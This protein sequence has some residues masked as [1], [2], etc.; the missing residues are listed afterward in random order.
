MTFWIL[1]IQLAA[2]FFVGLTSFGSNLFGIPLMTLVIGIKDAVIISLLATLP[3]WLLL[4]II[5]YKSMEW[6]EVLLLSLISLLTAPAGAWILAAGSPFL[7]VL[8]AGIC[9]WLILGW[10][11]L[12]RFLKREGKA[13][14][15]WLAAP[16]G[17]ISGVMIG[18]IGMG[19][20]PLM[21]YAFLR[22]W[23]KNATI[24]G[25]SLCSC[26]QMAVVAPAQWAGGLVDSG[27][28]WLSFW[29]ALAGIIGVGLSYP[30]VKKVS[31]TLFRNIMLAI[32]A[33]S[34]ATLLAK[35]FL[36]MN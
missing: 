20:P 16:V 17:L 25:G 28:I 21:I 2:G 34:A 27:L 32:L 7:L 4:S 15:K 5:Y 33:F 11:I 26:V 12:N 24:A 3:I 1:L 29:A 23:T 9:L 31:E 36:M 6:G 18:A 35:A 22:R 13:P 30:L 14:G 10:Q 8:L 19:G